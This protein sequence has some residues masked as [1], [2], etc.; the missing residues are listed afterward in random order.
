M[1]RAVL[2]AKLAEYKKLVLPA[3]EM[4]LNPSFVRTVLDAL[5]QKQPELLFESKL[6]E[7]TMDSLNPDSILINATVQQVL[8]AQNVKL[9]TEAEKQ[10]VA[11]NLLKLWLQSS[12]MDWKAFLS[13][14]DYQ[15]KDEVWEEDVLQG[16]VEALKENDLLK[17]RLLHK[18]TGKSQLKTSLSINGTLNEYLKSKRIVYRASQCTGSALL[19]VIH[20][21]HETQEKSFDKIIQENFISSEEAYDRTYWNKNGH[22]EGAL[23]ALYEENEEYVKSHALEKAVSEAKD[24]RSIEINKII[25]RYLVTVGIKLRRP[26][27]GA[28]L[29]VAVLKKHQNEKLGFAGILQKHY[30]PFLRE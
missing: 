1:C 25:N 29:R 24:A 3:E 10:V 7:A 13:L 30:F 12:G 6:Q 20:E 5:Y 28:G 22:I 26:A 19:A 2:I 9:P 4:F 16:A 23:K 27:S 17:P 15:L 18:A 8:A 14:F 21:K 11:S